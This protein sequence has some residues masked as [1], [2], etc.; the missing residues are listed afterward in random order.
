MVVDIIIQKDFEG[1]T[2]LE[3]VSIMDEIAEDPIRIDWSNTRDE[4]HA[5]R[6]YPKRQFI[7]YVRDFPSRD[8]AVGVLGLP[9]KIE[10]PV[11]DRAKSVLCDVQNYDWRAFCDENKIGPSTKNILLKLV[12]ESLRKGN[13]PVLVDI[14]EP[15]FLGG[16]SVV[17]VDVLLRI[18]GRKR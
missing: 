3:L 2:I 13:R 8:R 15:L 7:L 17:D 1:P 4:Q 5:L 14:I 9:L 6:S 16:I 11:L 10:Q 12:A 18:K